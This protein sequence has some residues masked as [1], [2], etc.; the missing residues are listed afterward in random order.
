M[1]EVCEG[2]SCSSMLGEAIVSE[3]SLTSVGLSHCLSGSSDESDLSEV[4][5]IHWRVL[6]S[7]IWNLFTDTIQDILPCC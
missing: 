6:D 5:L 7:L 4:S 2:K 3:Y 1:Q